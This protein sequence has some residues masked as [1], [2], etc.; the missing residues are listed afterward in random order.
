MSTT[1]GSLVSRRLAAQ[2]DLA[3][4]RLPAFGARLADADLATGERLRKRAEGVEHRCTRL[5]TTVREA[6][7]IPIGTPNA[8]DRAIGAIGG[9]AP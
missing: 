3:E 8:V 5:R 1:S 4:T 2:I 6:D 7:P 9:P